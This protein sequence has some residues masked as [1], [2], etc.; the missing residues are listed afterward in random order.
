MRRR[1]SSPSASPRPRSALFSSERS[2]T[3]S[4]GNLDLYSVVGIAAAA[5]EDI[6]IEGGAQLPAGATVTKAEDGTYLMTNEDASLSIAT[7]FSARIEQGELLLTNSPWDLTVLVATYDA[8][9]KMTGLQVVQTPGKHLSV[10]V[11]GETLT[12]FFLNRHS[13]P[14]CSTLPL[15]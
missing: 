13:A 14:I 4:G 8:D 10:T 9:G 12:A 6:R 3:I 7:P 15:E 5:L 2:I 11:T 1:R